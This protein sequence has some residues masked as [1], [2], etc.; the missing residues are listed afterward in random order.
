MTQTQPSSD[1]RVA[2]L[3]KAGQVRVALYVRLISLLHS[4]IA[5]AFR[6]DTEPDR[7]GGLPVLGR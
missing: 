1:P 7:E 4:Y 3:V 2:D 5:D 6:A